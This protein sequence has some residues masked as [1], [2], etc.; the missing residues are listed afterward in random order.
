[1]KSSRQVKAATFG[2]LHKA[3][4][5]ESLS[6]IDHWH[7]HE[8]WTPTKYLHPLK[9]GIGLCLDSIEVDI[10]QVDTSM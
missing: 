6:L 10:S 4:S 7:N 1:M 9:V 2:R 8:Q 5:V 3:L